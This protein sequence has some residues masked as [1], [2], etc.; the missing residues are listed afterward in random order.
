LIK[1]YEST[2]IFLKKDG[3][4]KSFI[5][6]YKYCSTLVHFHF[7]LTL[8]IYIVIHFMKFDRTLHLLGSVLLRPLH[9]VALIHCDSSDVQ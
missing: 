2:F 1:D 3:H 9:S 6:N 4:N 7:M 5:K 8:S